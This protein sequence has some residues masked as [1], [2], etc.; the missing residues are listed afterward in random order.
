MTDQSGDEVDNANEAHQ[1]Q[2]CVLV[3]SIEVP[4]A[5]GS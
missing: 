1:P 3:P 2:Y 4:K 5:Q